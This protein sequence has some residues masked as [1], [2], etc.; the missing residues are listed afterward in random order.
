MLTMENK[1]PGAT[2]I[3]L[4][5]G[6]A[7]SILIGLGPMLV[8]ARME[9]KPGE[10]EIAVGPP[11]VG[12]SIK[13][14]PVSI[15][16]SVAGNTFELTPLGIA[17]SVAKVTTR[18]ATP[19]GHELKSA[20]SSHQLNPMGSTVSAPTC[21]VKAMTMSENKAGAMGTNQASGP[22]AVK[23]AVVMIN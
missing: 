14:T 20:E 17:E 6:P 13:M 9:M 18:S 7:G 4:Q 11:A 3:T 22:G 10:I 5:S 23:G 8:G 15:Q 2:D 16:L 12:A 21:G 1:L 19:A